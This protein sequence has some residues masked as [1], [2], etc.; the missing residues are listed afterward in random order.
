M[1]VVVA[2][3]R[4][5]GTRL[6][7]MCQFS[8][9]LYKYNEARCQDFEHK[10]ITIKTVGIKCFYH[11]MLIFMTLINAYTIIIAYCYTGSY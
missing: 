8:T 2:T 3:C 11:L 6:Q 5:L 9:I 1:A 10:E 4:K 7:R